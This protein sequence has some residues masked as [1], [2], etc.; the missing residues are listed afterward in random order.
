MSFTF[1][2]LRWLLHPVALLAFAAAAQSWIDGA[3][4]RGIAAAGLGVLVAGATEVA[5]S[6]VR[7]EAKLAAPRGER[8]YGA[9]DILLIVFLGLLCL[10]VLLALLGRL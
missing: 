2:P 6:K 1:E 3:T 9:V 5:R 7:P 4:V 10:I 8:G